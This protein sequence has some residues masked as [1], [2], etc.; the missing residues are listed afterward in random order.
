MARVKGCL[1]WDEGRSARGLAGV[2][3]SKGE[4]L[5]EGRLVGGG[6]RVKVHSE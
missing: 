6:M 4:G 3:G 2:K 1:G 5:N